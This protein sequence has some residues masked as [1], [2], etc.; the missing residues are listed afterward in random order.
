MGG[1][2]ASDQDEGSPGGGER[3]AEGD[4]AAGDDHDDDDVRHNGNNMRDGDNGHL[5]GSGNSGGGGGDESDKIGESKDGLRDSRFVVDENDMDLD[6]DESAPGAKGSRPGSPAAAG[7][8]GAAG[9]RPLTPPPEVKSPAATVVFCLFLVYDNSVSAFCRM[10]PFFFEFACFSLIH[11]FFGAGQ[12]TECAGRGWG[13]S[14]FFFICVFMV[15]MDTSFLS[16]VLSPFH[17]RQFFCFFLRAVTISVIV[18]YT[19]A[20]N[21]VDVFFTSPKPSW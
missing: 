12:L 3:G 11:L 16:N 4:H 18:C 15:E 6:D 2:G 7:P 10:C 21:A 9:G 14:I 19:T 1:D 20:A 5:G 13:P 17:S 8:G